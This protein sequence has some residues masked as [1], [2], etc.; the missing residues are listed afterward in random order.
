ML[1]ARDSEELERAA[2]ELRD[3]GADVHPYAI[4]LTKDTAPE[5][6]IAECKHRF[7]R[8]DILINN[9]G[10]IVVGPIENMEESDFD[11]CLKLHVWAPLR[12]MNAALPELQARRGRIVNIASIG[13]KVP[14]PHLA[15]YSVSKFA[16]AGLSGAYQAELAKDGV[17]VTTVYPGLL[18]T[19]SHLHAQF[20]GQR[21]KEFGWFAL[22]SA[23]PLTSISVD[24]AAAQIVR[25]AR[26]GTPELVIS[27][28]AKLLTVGIS[29]LPNFS[30]RILGWVSRVLPAKGA[31]GPAQPGYR[32]RGAFPPRWMTVLAE[33][34]SKRNNQV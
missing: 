6:I 25:A 34:A 28:Q 21:E 5:E 22:G 19:G 10:V 30:G 11:H 2:R 1:V 9:A 12:L 13:A 23:T 18:R 26:R 32:A 20:K 4:D 17:K 8:L 33:A 7:G 27:V 16:L 14:I 15:P 24:R 31:P 3:R 29:L